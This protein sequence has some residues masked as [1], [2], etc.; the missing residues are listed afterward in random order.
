MEW[1]IVQSA[2]QL[3]ARVNPIHRADAASAQLYR[4]PA[5]PVWFLRTRANAIPVPE[6]HAEVQNEPSLTAFVLFFSF[7]FL[8]RRFLLISAPRS[9]TGVA[10]PPLPIVPSRDAALKNPHDMPLY[11]RAGSSPHHRSRYIFGR[12][13]R[14]APPI[15]LSR[16]TCVAL[17]QLQI[18]PSRFISCL[19]PAIFRPA[20]LIPASPTSPQHSCLEKTINS[21][22]PQSAPAPSAPY[23]AGKSCRPY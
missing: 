11:L 16:P 12:S 13:S 6:R 18:L 5:A 19:I 17:R 10:G 20:F 15:G 1:C 21:P 14:F 2:R 4:T 3:C 7:P 9:S 23:S 8:I 22:P